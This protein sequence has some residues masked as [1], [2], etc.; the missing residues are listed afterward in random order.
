MSTTPSPMPYSPRNPRPFYARGGFWLLLVILAGLVLWRVTAGSATAGKPG[1]VAPVAIRAATA[2]AQAL[3]VT[4]QAVGNVVAYESVAVRARLDSQVTAVHFKDGDEV[5]KGDL[6]FELDDNALRA[7][8]A[9]LTA[10]MAR[11][12]AQAE[13]A[14]RQSS[15]AEALAQKGFATKATQDDSSANLAVAQASLNASQAALESVR[16]QL[17]YTRITAPISGRTGTI[18]VTLGNTVKA[19]DPQALVTINQLKP[20]R[21]QVSLPQQHFQTLRDA[22]AQGDVTVTASKQGEAGDAATIA[23]GT[24]DYIDNAVDATTGTFVTRAG[25]ANEDERLLPGMFVTATLSLGGSASVLTVPE[26]AVQRG[27]AGDYVFVI[28]GE[29]ALKREVSVARL[30]DGLAVIAQGIEAGERVAT[31]GLLS[32]SDGSVVK[33]QTE[34]TA[35]APAAA[36]SNAP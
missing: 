7:R 2:T 20:I 36:E 10:N 1:E 13:N 5:K 15:R 14:R 19:N 8:A 9:E 29:K 24:L 22:M 11:D 27:Q 16:V 32:L 6:L 18:N 21:V 12:K 26:V 33:L 4:L 28:V 23:T 3:P 30:Q 34:T 31:D 35:P 25:F 17:G